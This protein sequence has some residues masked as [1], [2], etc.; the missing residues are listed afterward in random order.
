MDRLERLHVFIRVVD[1]MSFTRAAESLSI[2]RS[3]VSTAV[4][5]LESKLGTRLINRTT[6]ALDITEEGQLLYKQA[7]LLLEDYERLTGAF[8]AEAGRPSGKLRINVPGRL[9][10]RVLVPALPDFLDRYPD[11][12]IQMGVTDRAV[13]LVGEGVDCVIRVGELADSNLIARPLGSLPLCNCASPAYLARFG[14]PKTI[15]DLSAHRIVAF[16]SSISGSV[17]SWEYQQGG[18]VESVL[19]P[20]RVTVNTAEA[21]IAGALAGLGLIQVPHYDV[22]HH[23]DAG[24]LVNVLPMTVPE[25]MPISLLY[26]HR[27]HMTRRLEAFIDWVVPILQSQVLRSSNQEP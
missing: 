15:A 7:L 6:R 3:T 16:V 17:E 23:L 12:D 25:P 24:S 13:D 2:P 10:R 14:M 19:L 1:C 22:R 4:K 27:E 26:P 8:P 18:Q 5:N 11:I 20:A 21:L 9:G